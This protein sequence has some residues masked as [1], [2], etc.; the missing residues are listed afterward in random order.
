[1]KPPNKYHV[2]LAEQE[3]QGNVIHLEWITGQDG[4]KTITD[5]TVATLKAKFDFRPL[6]EVC[7]PQTQETT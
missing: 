3:R 5:E 7:Y 6:F 4:K 2:W 1:M